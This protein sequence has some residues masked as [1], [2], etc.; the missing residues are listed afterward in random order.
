MADQLIPDRASVAEMTG[1]RHRE[2]QSICDRLGNIARL[3]RATRYGELSILLLGGAIPEAVAYVNSTHFWEKHSSWGS[4]VD[5]WIMVGLVI[6]G[7]FVRKVSKDILEQHADS[8]D[9][10]KATVDGLLDAYDLSPLQPRTT[11]HP[12]VDSG[13]N[14]GQS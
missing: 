14:I 4:P 5:L 13:P 11:G 10:V 2:L 6:V 8:I 3:T 1:I 9:G 12:I 7:A